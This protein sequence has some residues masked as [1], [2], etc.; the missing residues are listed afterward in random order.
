MIINNEVVAMLC[1]KQ[2]TF[3]EPFYDRF[4]TDS[5]IIIYGA[6]NLGKQIEEILTNRN[7]K[8]HC[9]IDKDAEKIKYIKDI[10]VYSLDKV[11]IPHLQ[12]K[13]YL[14]ILGLC[15]K[16]KQ[17][18]VLIA[19]LQ[20]E[21]FSRFVTYHSILSEKM[22]QTNQP[23]CKNKILKA[24]SLL[25]DEQSRETFYLTLKAHLEKEYAQA[26]YHTELTQYFNVGARMK[27]GFA[28]FV[29]CGAYIG[30]SLEKALEYIKL[31]E[32][33]GFEPDHQNFSILSNTVDRHTDEIGKAVLFPCACGG[34]VGT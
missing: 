32:Y 21:G 19:Q 31:E 7:Y 20:K 17:Y 13:E 24:F 5:K 11:S 3:S 6:G 27:K 12:H 29:D 10:P 25:N 14:V 2:G 15:M 1:D 34:A 30:D 26:P 16:Q 33:Y 28:R 9:F 8:I 18:D 4:H 23:V 22:F